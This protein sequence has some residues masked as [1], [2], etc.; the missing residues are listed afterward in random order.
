MKVVYDD[1][2]TDLLLRMY[3]AIV[4]NKYKHMYDNYHLSITQNKACTSK[5]NDYICDVSA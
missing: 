2:D 4:W 3:I 1:I 5:K